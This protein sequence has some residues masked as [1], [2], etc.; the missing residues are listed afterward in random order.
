MERK[1]EDINKAQSLAAMTPQTTSVKIADQLRERIIDGY[2]AP[3][4]QINEV[5]VSCL[6]NL[7]RGPLREVLQRLSQE[8]LL[9]SKPNRGVFVV[10][11]T[12]EDA[13]EINR[14][15]GILEL[16]AAEIITTQSFERRRQVSQKLAE[17]AAEQA[18]PGNRHQP[19]AGDYPERRPAPAP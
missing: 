19:I 1:C 18:S 2:F 14:V 3:G 16:G 5:L 15:R 7:S 4:Q 13:D 12:Q 10:D 9:V 17:I 8:G 11:L 6:L